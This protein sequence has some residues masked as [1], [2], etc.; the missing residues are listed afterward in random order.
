MVERMFVFAKAQVSSFTG[1]IVDYLVMI[2]LTEFFHLHYTLSIVAGGIIG[3]VVNFAIN[4]IWAF[5]SKE[6][7]Y[8]VSG[9]RQLT[10]FLL[11][12]MNSIILKTSGTYFFTSFLAIDYKISRIMTDLFVSLIFNFTLQKHWVFK[13]QKQPQ[14]HLP[15]AKK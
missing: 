13:R 2:I 11:V 14:S 3:A 15:L 8:Q 9:R 1:G 4:R 12:V 7:P 6:I 10:R 5:R